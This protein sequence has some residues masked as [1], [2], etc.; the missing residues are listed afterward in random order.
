[1]IK[2]EHKFIFNFCL[3]IVKLNLM[4]NFI[5]IL[6]QNFFLILY[7]FLN[8]FICNKYQIYQTLELLH[9]NFIYKV[10][11]NKFFKYK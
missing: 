10:L 11:F 2:L 5:Y 8:F 7:K 1:M 9:F 6:T 3:K 4:F